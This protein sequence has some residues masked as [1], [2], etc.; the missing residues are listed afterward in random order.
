MHAARTHVAEAHDQD[1]TFSR[2][3]RKDGA[4][5]DMTRESAARWRKVPRGVSFRQPGENAPLPAI[6]ISPPRA[7]VCRHAARCH[8]LREYHM[9]DTL[10]LLLIRTHRRRLPGRPL[11]IHFVPRRWIPHAHCPR[12]IPD[13]G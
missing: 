2:C 4:D 7:H 1:S 6:Q 9:R 13:A 10:M 8:L 3:A 12:S 5:A 11:L